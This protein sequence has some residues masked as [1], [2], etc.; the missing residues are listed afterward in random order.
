MSGWIDGW[1]DSFLGPGKKSCCG[2]RWRFWR[3]FL[4]CEKLRVC[5]CLCVWVV[6]FSIIFIS[7]VIGWRHVFVDVTTWKCS[8]VDNLHLF[9]YWIVVQLWKCL[10]H[11]SLF[12]TCSKC[13]HWCSRC[14]P[15]VLSRLRIWHCSHTSCC[16]CCGREM[17][18]SR[19]WSDCFRPTSVVEFD[20]LR[21][22][23]WQVFITV[24]F[25]ND[26]TIDF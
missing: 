13:W 17:V 5:T 19:R 12:R 22:T 1:M 3:L 2:N 15:R 7:E 26:P 8:P 23:N 16:Q 9:T 18:T 20:R 25:I 4:V 10:L 24:A 6:V 11:Q 14:M 21:Q